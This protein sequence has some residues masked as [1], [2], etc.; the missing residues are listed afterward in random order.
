MRAWALTTTLPA[1]AFAAYDNLIGIAP[2]FSGLSP[3]ALAAGR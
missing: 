1:E 3:A 2:D